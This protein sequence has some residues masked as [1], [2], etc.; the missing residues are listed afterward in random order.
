[1]DEQKRVLTST[2]LKPLCRFL[3]ELSYRHGLLKRVA[4]GPQFV[5]SALGVENET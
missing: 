2:I 5:V 4:L 1:M 3:D